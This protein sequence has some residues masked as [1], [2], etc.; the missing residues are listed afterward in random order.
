MMSSDGRQLLS[1]DLVYP[2]VLGFSNVETGDVIWLGGGVQLLSDYL[3]YPAVWGF[4]N[5]VT[6]IK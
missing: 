3:V 6:D 2:A 1:D 4:S 5:V